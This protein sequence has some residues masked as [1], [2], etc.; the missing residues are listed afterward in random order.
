MKKIL[1][2]VITLLPLAALG[3]DYPKN[4]EEIATDRTQS[5]AGRLHQ[6]F[7]L[8]WERDL[9][10]SPEFATAIG[11]PGLDDRWTDESREA[12]EKRK[13]EMQWPLAV[14]TT[15]GRAKLPKG[16]QLNYDLFRRNL[17]L[18]IDGTKF[19]SELLA[20]SQ[21]DGV[22]QSVAQVLAKMRT[23]SVNAY[24]NRLTRLRA[25]P[26][27][28]EQNIA[29]LKRGLAQGIT[30]S[31]ITLREVPQQI[32][33]VIPDDPMQSALLRSFMEFPEHIP[34]VEQERLRATAV[35]IYQKRIVSAY[36][37]LHDF[38]TREYL[39]GARTSIGF[40]SL[41]NGTRWYAFAVRRH[42]TTSMTPKE[43]HELGL[44]EVTRIR[45]EMDK[46]IAEA[47]F[48]GGFEDFIKFLRTDP[49]FFYTTS[50]ALLAGYRDIA[51]RIDPELLRLFGKL[52]RLPYGVKAVPAYA[53][54]PS[55]PRITKK[56][57]RRQG[58]PAGF[59]LRKL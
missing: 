11:Y 49:Q 36:K 18:E 21:L 23:D 48:K 45:G 32:L 35:Q 41:P 28:I 3:G 50:E 1:L 16:D 13:A 15:I 40:S 4:Y 39:P 59:S 29:L 47:K 7:D 58:A 33:N 2:L 22:Q 26:G 6:L 8:D 17:E 46:V 34:R 42:T 57:R 54:K 20:L 38:L 24:E 44:R 43:I 56:A 51:K 25:V 31:K 14:I 9:H 52:P 27:L 53:E 10:E 37:K 30:P 55:P 19:P 5:D 12:I